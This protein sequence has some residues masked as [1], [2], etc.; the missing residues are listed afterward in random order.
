MYCQIKHQDDLYSSKYTSIHCCVSVKHLLKGLALICH[1][2]DSRVRNAA[3]KVGLKQKNHTNESW[4]LFTWIFLS[5]NLFAFQ[6]ET[7][8]DLKW[9]CSSFS[10]FIL[11]STWKTTRETGETQR[12]KPSHLEGHRLWSWCQ[13]LQKHI[14]GLSLQTWSEAN[15]NH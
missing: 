3:L 9:T 11:L 13:S 5:Q 15:W 6:G 14:Q 12:C 2:Q 8:R 1:L 7:P 10:A 4:R